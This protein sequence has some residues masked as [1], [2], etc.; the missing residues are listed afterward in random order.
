MTEQAIVNDNGR[1]RFRRRRSA[2]LTIVG[3][4][5][6]R[7]LA[8]V[9]R[10]FFATL[11][12]SLLAIVTLL[13]IIG[14]LM[15]YSSTFDWSNDT[16]GTATGFFVEEHLRKRALWRHGAYVFSRQLIIGSGS[17]FRCGCCS[18]PSAL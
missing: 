8:P 12:K 9:K 6:T 1:R 5:N 13:L 3:D 16:Y 18:S 4:D 10:G 15:V 2:G 17:V 11:D 7:P 14:S